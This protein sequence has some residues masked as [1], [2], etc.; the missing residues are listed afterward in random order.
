MELITLTR[1]FSFYKSITSTP[2]GIIK[3]GILE[4]N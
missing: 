1:R 3:Y 2:K 4:K